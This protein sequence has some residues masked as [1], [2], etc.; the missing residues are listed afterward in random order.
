[1]R[2]E[3]GK[4]KGQRKKFKA[5]FSRLGTKTNYKGYAE[6]T[7][8]LTSVIDPETN[9]PVA[10]H[11]WFNFTKGFEI[12][13]LSTGGTVE[14]EAR[15]KEY[16]KGYVNSRYQINRRKIDYKLSHPTKIRLIKQAR[17]IDSGSSLRK[18]WK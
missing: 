8:L 15:I 13:G 17:T 1:M 14:F 11:V 3:L 6:A 18:E 9:T 7:V 12:A 4:S 2:K 5:I 16:K 10:D